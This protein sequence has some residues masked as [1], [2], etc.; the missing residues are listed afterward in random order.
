MRNLIAVGRLD[1]D[2]E[3]LLLL[4][5]DGHTANRLMHPRYQ[6]KRVYEARVDGVPSESALRRCADGIDL[7]DPTPARAEV[8][9]VHRLKDGAREN[10]VVRL[11]LREGRKREVKRLMREIG[12]RVRHLKRIALAG[13]TTKGLNP[14]DWRVLEAGE[15]AQLVNRP[16]PEA[17]RN[18]R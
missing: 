18:H 4:T 8:V 15:I 5:S 13:L 2:T 10:A 6:V 9:I 3:G 11:T 16:E 7:G 17:P 14:G 1:Y 12:H